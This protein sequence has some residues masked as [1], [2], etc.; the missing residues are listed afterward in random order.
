MFVGLLPFDEFAWSSTPEEGRQD[1]DQWIRGYIGIK[2]KKR[3]KRQKNPD[4]KSRSPQDWTGQDYPVSGLKQLAVENPKAFCPSSSSRRFFGR[5][6]M[7]PAPPRGV[8]LGLKRLKR[9]GA[10]TKGRKSSI[11]RTTFLQIGVEFH[12]RERRRSWRSVA[13]P[14]AEKELAGTQY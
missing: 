1:R 13:R 10:Q 3:T 8:A 7:A 9:T 6:R 2:D 14:G 4:L 11:L 5:Q 12:R